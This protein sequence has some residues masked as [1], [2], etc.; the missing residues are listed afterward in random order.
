MCGRFNL[1]FSQKG[2]QDI[3]EKLPKSDM[4]VQ[5]RFGDI[6]PKNIAPLFTAESDKPSLVRWGFNRFNGKGLLSMPVQKPLRTDRLSVRAFW[7][8]AA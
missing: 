8:D 1:G 5:L 2:V 7:K 3:V 6:F 4:N